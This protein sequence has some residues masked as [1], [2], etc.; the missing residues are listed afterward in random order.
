MSNDTKLIIKTYKSPQDIPKGE[1]EGYLW[2][3]NEKKPFILPSAA[4]PMEDWGKASYL[5]EG[6][7]YAAKENVSILIRHTG[8]Y[9][10]RAY[11]MSQLS[12]GIDA[13]AEE[14]KVVEKVEIVEKDLA[15][16]AYRL[17]NIEKLRFR[18]LWESEPDPNCENMEVLKLKALIFVGFTHLKTEENAKR[19]ENA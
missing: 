5:V 7:L 12:E 13:A 18:Q 3:A 19:E 4:Y 11:D 6:L 17:P 15:Y 8:S 9:C 16:L 14:T 10:I 1:Y 2:E